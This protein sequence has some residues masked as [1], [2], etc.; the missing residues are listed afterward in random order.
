MDDVPHSREQ[1]HQASVA[2]GKADYQT[3]RSQTPCSHVD[4]AQDKGCQGEGAQAQGRWV[5]NTAILDLLV[6]TR[7]ELSSE[8][9]QARFTTGGVDMSERTVAEASGSFGGLVF[10]MGHFTVHAAVAVGFFVVVVGSVASEFS[11]GLRGHC[12]GEEIF[13]SPRGV[14]MEVR[15]VGGLNRWVQEWQR[16]EGEGGLYSNLR[17]VLRKDIF[18]IGETGGRRCRTGE[19]QSAGEV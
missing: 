6:G 13:E 2:K 4:Q 8:G 17:R 15:L 19:I 1:L 11:V 10:V 12:D 9:R 7:L 5:G 18:G 3:G 16:G 14:E